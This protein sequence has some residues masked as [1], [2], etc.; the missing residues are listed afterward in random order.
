MPHVQKSVGLAEAKLILHPDHQPPSG[1][2]AMP[3]TP[4][5]IPDPGDPAPP[6]G[7]SM[8]AMPTTLYG[9]MPGGAVILSDGLLRGYV[10]GEEG[11]PDRLVVLPDSLPDIP[12]LA[13]EQ[14]P[15]STVASGMNFQSIRSNDSLPELEGYTVDLELGRGGMGVVF[16][17]RQIALNRVVAIK[18]LHNDKADDSMIS[19]FRTEAEAIA[20]LDHPHIIGIYEIGES[21]GKPWFSLEYCPRGTLERRIG[22]KPMAGREA[23]IT[24]EKLA[25]AVHVAHEAGIIHRD[26]KPAN[27]LIAADDS[28]RVTD[29]GIARKTDDDRSQ[30]QTGMIIGTPSYMSPEQASGRTHEIGPATDIYALGAILYECLTGRPPFVGTTPVDTIMQVNQQLVVPPRLL[31]RNI[32]V[33]LEKIV[34]KC[35]EKKSELRYATALALAED[36]HLQLNGEEISA[37][38]IHIFERL[39]RELSGTQNETQLRPWGNVLIVL[40]L[41]VLISHTLTSIMIY[42]RFNETLSF[43]LPRMIIIVPVLIGT[44][45][46]RESRSILPTNALE[47]TIWA[48]WVGYLLAF[49]SLF[50]AMHMQGHEHLDIYGP[51]MALSGMLWFSLGGYTWGGC[52][53]LGVLFM[54]AAPLMSKL[55]A[56]H[57]GPFSFGAMWALALSLL[58]A[59]YRRISRP[60]GQETPRT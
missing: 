32:D 47:R 51:A 15:P 44:M 3:D 18:M 23:A 20:R 39:G 33:D 42:E 50:W 40:G 1:N 25:R 12:G 35:L 58:G 28:P 29:F 24:V 2:A 56:T 54:L 9:T 5:P 26:L 59:H 53:L 16:R 19:R 11:E 49:T 45:R 8:V 34:L 38:S 36:L 60:I 46:L 17:G 57:W 14:E 6:T 41:V 37:R 43:W 22:G 30:T 48:G 52:Y 27:I 4:F 10:P 7:S 13:R 21:D 55:G 31:N